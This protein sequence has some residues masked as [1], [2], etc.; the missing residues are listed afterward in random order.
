MFWAK[1]LWGLLA[2]T[3][4]L[5]CSCA[6]FWQFLGFWLVLVGVTKPTLLFLQAT[7]DLG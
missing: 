6:V 3:A 5:L 2:C 7:P 4:V 1:L